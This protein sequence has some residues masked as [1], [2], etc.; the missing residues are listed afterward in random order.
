MLNFRACL[1]ERMNYELLETI[2]AACLV[3]S[4]LGAVVLDRVRWHMQE[5]RRMKAL[6]EAGVLH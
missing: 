6:L 3:V 2:G 1:G 5:K 4:I